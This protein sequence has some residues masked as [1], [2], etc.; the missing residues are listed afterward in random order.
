MFDVPQRIKLLCDICDIRSLIECRIE[1][2][3]C[4]CGVD[5]LDIVVTFWHIRKGEE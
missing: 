4:T 2:E 3:F 5:K 1:I